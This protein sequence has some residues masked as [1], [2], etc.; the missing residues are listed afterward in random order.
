[1]SKLNTNGK[2]NWKNIFYSII[3]SMASILLLVFFMP[4]EHVTRYSYH[5]GEPWEENPLIAQESFPVFKSEAQIQ[6]EKDSLKRY[7]E[8]YFRYDE[9]ILDSQLVHLNQEY[10]EKLKEN[11]P[12]YY[13]KR[14]H[15][16]L[17][18]VYLK[19]ILETQDYEMLKNEETKNIRIYQ[20]NESR[21]RPIYTLY[22]Q[23]TAYEYLMSET[24]SIHFTHAKL[25]QFKMDHFIQSNLSY[26][27]AKSLQ[28]R[29]EMD[30]MLI[31]Y[32]GQVQ[33]G[34]RIV[35]RGEIINEYTYQVLRSME[36]FQA[37][38]T[39][40]AVERFSELAGQVIY[41]T[42]MIVLLFCFFEQFRIKYLQ[43]K[44]YVML[45]LFLFLFFPIVTFSVVRHNP[46]AVYLIPYC[47]L[48]IFIRIFADSRTG[49][50]VHLVMTLTCAI[51][52]PHPFE[53]VL[54]QSAIGLVTIF[55]MR[56]LSERSDLF[57]T[58]LIVLFSSLIIYGCLDLIQ[59]SFFTKRDF[60]SSTYIYLCIAGGLSLIS[61][62]L[63]IPIERI[64][65]F[66]SAVTLMELSN[67]NHPILRSMSEN[68]PGTFQ[69]SL[70]VAN[71]AAEV[72]NQIGG[73]AQLVRA[74]ALYHD[75]GKIENA[76]FFTENQNGT[77]PHDKLTYEQSAQIIIQHVANGLKLAEKHKLPYVI[78]EFI[79]THHGKSMTK[80]FYI[81]CKNR[82]PDQEIDKEL[83]T[84]PGPNPR[85]LEQAILMMADAVEAASRSLPEYTE[86]SI[87]TLVEKIIDGQTEE[88]CFKQCDITFQNI[89]D[90]KEVFK[91]KLKTIYHTRVQYPEMKKTEHKDRSHF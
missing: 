36:K 77:N 24:D 54:I 74:G 90:A 33:T 44:R 11:I 9:T 27:E 88:G 68:A 80:Y 4:R 40:S 21:T 57:R 78:R 82:Y 7:Y 37:E 50:F 76:I 58:A 56:Q 46:S 87:N 25:Q 8:P 30:N 85:T 22:T 17:R 31:P 32:M 84:Y 55:S 45:I 28:Q 69:H 49:F 23:K 19:G 29:Q 65:H 18:E 5:M 14:M 64:F 67:I 66:T 86:D 63:L 51:S 43:D 38:R 53:F 79:R 73:E 48:P 16:K 41:A 1:M 35:D 26:D 89:A 10:E 75:I 59:G 47:I 70:Q 61:Y 81:S 39:K 3:L 42:L 83:F 72:A 2:R 62:L 6:L 60:S 13:L 12:H 15:E 91:E 20:G 52:L 71:L 34:Q